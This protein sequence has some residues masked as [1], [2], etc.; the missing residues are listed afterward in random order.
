MATGI[1]WLYVI[2]DGSGPQIRRTSHSG[3]TVVVNQPGNY[4]VTLPVT[5]SG[6]AAVATLGN[7]VGTITAVPGENT[8]LA[9]NQI[10]V[11]TLTLQNQLSPALDFSLA[12]FYRVRWPWWPWVVIGLAAIA[13][14]ALVGR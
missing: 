3:I 9:P 8:G 12:A 13:F 5:V 10:S 2:N 6:L 1:A 11:S 4:T 14:Y 7:S